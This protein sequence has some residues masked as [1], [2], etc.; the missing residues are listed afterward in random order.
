MASSTKIF[1]ISQGTP[2]SAE[3]G[4]RFLGTGSA[5]TRRALRR[6]VHPNTSLEP[7]VYFS[8]PD[9]TINLD[10]QVLPHPITQAIMALEGTKVVR[11]D[12]G[13]EDVIVTEVWTAGGGK[14]AMPTFFWR[15]LYEYLDNEPTY[16]PITPVYIQWEPRD[17]TDKVYNVEL[18]SCLV[19]SGGENDFFDVLDFRPS[20][21]I[22]D[23]DHPSDAMGILD[24]LTTEETGVI[25]MEVRLQMR[26]VSEEP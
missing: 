24:D 26:I 21:G 4:I 12:R 3:V 6:L 10:N 2:T 11:F 8:N 19:G 9:R 23:P 18:L 17:R 1:R 13:E 14:L 25:D 5:G 16:D 20:G 22:Y 7:L 15:L